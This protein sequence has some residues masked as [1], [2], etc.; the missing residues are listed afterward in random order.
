FIRSPGGYAEY[1]LHKQNIQATLQV[2]E[3][4]LKNDLTRE[5]EWL[6][7]G[8][9]A[10][11]TKQSARINSAEQ[12]KED[13]EILKGL[14]RSREIAIEMSSGQRSPKKLVEVINLTLS[15]PS[16]ERPLF[17]NLDLLIHR[18]TR[19]GLLGDNGSGKS[20]LIEALV[21]EDPKSKALIIESGQ[22]KRYEDLVINR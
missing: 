20:S 21:N 11:Q 9:I 6:R 5:T 4:R 14:N 8:S 15:R 3:Q 16:R 12:L 7:R 2:Q 1:L 22:V 19:L 13:V 18:H 10:R 17:Q